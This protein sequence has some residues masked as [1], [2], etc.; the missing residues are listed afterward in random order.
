MSVVLRCT[1]QDGVVA[2]LDI[3]EEVDLKDDISAIETGE[4][5][6]VFGISSQQF[7][8]PNTKTN[9]DFFGN[10]DNLGATPS[11]GFIK[12]VPCQVLYNGMEIF[13]GKLYIKDIITNQK[14]DTIYQ[15]V[16][17]NE[18]VDFSLTI[19]NLQMQDLDFSEYTH[20]YVYGNITSSWSNNL[21]AGDIVY[22]LINY[23]INPD[24]G[25]SSLIQAGGQ[26]GNF[27]NN[28]TPLTVLDWRPTIRAK[29][30]VDK[31]FESTGF[32]YTSSFLDSDYFNS[33]YIVS[34]QD[35]KSGVG[36]VSPASQSFYA[37]STGSQYIEN[38]ASAFETVN[39]GNEVYDNNN[40]YDPIN[41]EFTASADGEYI[42][43]VFLNLEE[44]YVPPVPG[45]P[46]IETSVEVRFVKNGTDVL[47]YNFIPLTQFGVQPP[48]GR[49]SFPLNNNNNSFTL[50]S[51]DIITFEMRYN[52]E[53]PGGNPENNLIILPSRVGRQNTKFQL[54]Q[55]P[56]AIIGG[57]VNI[58]NIFN[59]TDKVIDLF[60]GIIQKFNL[61]ITPSL[62]N[63][64]TLQV[65]PFNT[66]VDLGN[67]TD[68]TDIVDR[69]VK[70]KIEHPVQTQ[71]K[72]ILFTDV[73]DKDEINADVKRLDDLIYG[74][75][76][77]ESDSDLASSTRKVGTYFAPTPYKGIEGG[78]DMVL[79]NLGDT[80]GKMIAYKPRLLHN[81]GFYSASS[82]LIEGNFF[83]RDEDGVVHNHDQY[84]HFSHLSN[85]P[86]D[87]SSSLDLHFGNLTNPGF[88]PPHQ[89][90]GNGFVERS[91]YYEYWSQYVNEIYDVDARLLT[92]NVLLDPT[93]IP[94]LQLNDKIFIDGHYYRID[95]IKGASLINEKSVE[96]TLLKTLP[97]KNKYLRRRVVNRYTGEKER[98]VIVKEVYENGTAVYQDY[99]TTETLSG[100][101]LIDPS[102]KD[103][104]TPF[105]NGNQIVWNTKKVTSGPNYTNNVIGDNTINPNA[106]TITISGNKNVIGYRANQ[107]TIA[108]DNNIVGDA[109]DT[110]EIFGDRNQTGFRSSYISA[111]NTSDTIITSSNNTTVIGSKFITAS[112]LENNTILSIDGTTFQKALF[113]GANYVTGST[114]IGDVYFEGDYYLSK[115]TQ[116]LLCSASANFNIGTGSLQNKYVYHVDYIG[117]AGDAT[118]TLPA[119]DVKN[120]G[121]VFLFKGSE[122]IDSENTIT[123][124]SSG[125]SDPINDT[126]S[127][128]LNKP[129]AW[130]ELRSGG[131]QNSGSSELGWS[132]IRES[133]PF[134]AGFNTYPT[135]SGLGGTYELEFDRYNVIQQEVQGNVTYT[136]TIPPA[137]SMCTLIIYANV[138]GARTATFSGSSFLDQGNLSY[139]SPDWYTLTFVS[140][141][142]KLFEVSR[143]TALT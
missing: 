142:S 97:R 82:N 9:Q 116:T 33:L 106:K 100:S 73:E 83:I 85:F 48:G 131:Y 26:F 19:K 138:G 28:S 110:I 136:A 29:A 57:D 107:V 127:Y 70:W 119:I 23:G 139:S 103:G 45:D 21:F 77:F 69:S 41:S 99:N 36:F 94:Q 60:K 88:Y 78:D 118:I 62:Y 124:I 51:G 25:S 66:W 129:H 24:Y 93:D 86:A 31:I 4:I 108:G 135:S 14:G 140:N 68:W 109:N 20:T 123:I 59:P 47:T 87:F 128:I 134:P 67:T 2:D 10:L 54:L 52:I 42:F 89:D 15:T 80:E 37:L 81:L 96:V 114:I 61:V 121:Q 22:P 38:T 117:A 11:V 72:E 74:Q 125:S 35:A 27:D 113:D 17:V 112:N 104:L 130:V 91:A 84:I 115:T 40:S 56:N 95:K 75:Y 1:N 63:K 105:E 3:L 64:N 143:T 79:P 32:Q 90:V 50:V 44:E 55:G 111:L 126:T 34:T 120:R 133:D 102:I 18:T 43:A 122:T 132:V 12:S 16:A 53:Q 49:Y 8:L 76:T 71:P 13:T 101:L 137:G 65:E 98:D 92:C 5:G 6:E 39:F 46:E 30:V 58:G 7:A 141:G